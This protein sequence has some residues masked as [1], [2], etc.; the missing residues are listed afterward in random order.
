ML[1]AHAVLAVRLRRRAFA[2]DVLVFAVSI[3]LV[4]TAWLDPVILQRINVNSDDARIVLGILSCIAFLLALVQLLVDWKLRA[5]DHDRARE[6]LA[7]LKAECR[8][9][10]KQGESAFID[11]LTSWMRRA[12]ALLA[13][14]TPI[15][16]SA[17]A[18]LKA[19]HRRKVEISRMLDAHP[20]ASLLVLRAW[21]RLRD[22]WR[23]VRSS[24]E[25]GNE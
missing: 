19:T 23:V 2:L 3:L 14:L 17:F 7:G 5:G 9:F 15:P 1:T 6:T 11:D 4:A 10:Q 13:T 24:R 12:D 8:A 20:G 25:H 18:A 16:D 22:T 21:L